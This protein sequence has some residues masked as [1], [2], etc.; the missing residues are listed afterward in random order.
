MFHLV[1]QVNTP[2]FP[3]ALPAFTIFMCAERVTG[4]GEI[5]P[6]KINISLN[7]ESLATY[8]M[9]IRFDDADM[10]RSIGTMYGFFVPFPGTLRVHAIQLGQEIALWEIPC[11]Q[12]GQPE[13][14]FTETSKPPVG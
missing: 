11:N 13:L 8:D 10:A 4:E 1:E 5:D 12:I 3:F 2:T 14:E 9:D 6:I 7:G